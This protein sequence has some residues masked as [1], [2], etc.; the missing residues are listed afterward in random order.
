MRF[1]KKLVSAHEKKDDKLVDDEKLQSEYIEA[2]P[3]PEPLQAPSNVKKEKGGI[4]SMLFGGS[5][6]EKEEPVSKIWKIEKDDPIHKLFRYVR[7]PLMD[8]EYFVHKVMPLNVLPES[9]QLKVLAGAYI[10]PTP[11]SLSACPICI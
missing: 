10:S 7:F 2:F 9:D 4:L 11:L 1:L 6:K 3:L 5:K 8:A